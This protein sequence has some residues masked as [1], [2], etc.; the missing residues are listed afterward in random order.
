MPHRRR[1]PKAAFET[2]EPLRGK[3]DLR[4]QNQCLTTLAQAFGH[5]LEIDLGLAGPSHPI[6]QSDRKRPR[7]HG[8]AKQGGRRNL[9]SRQF[10]AVVMHRIGDGKRRSGWQCSGDH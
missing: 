2:L 10:L 5:C 8:L 7:R 9:F 4:Q 1:H 6:Q 3:R